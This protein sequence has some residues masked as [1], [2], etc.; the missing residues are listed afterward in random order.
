MYTSGMWENTY[1]Y[2][3]AGPAS[4]FLFFYP[5]FYFLSFFSLFLLFGG[6][7]KDHDT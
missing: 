1:V 6:G 2:S 3:R 5:F 7:E 4:H